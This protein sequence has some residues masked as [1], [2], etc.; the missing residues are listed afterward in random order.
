MFRRYFNRTVAQQD[1][2]LVQGNPFLK[3]G[4]RERVPELM[5]MS[6]RQTRAPKNLLQNLVPM[7][8]RPLTSPPPRPEKIIAAVF[9]FREFVQHNLRQRYRNMLAGFL[10]VQKY[11]SVLDRIFAQPDG[12]P[13]SQTGMT[14]RQNK[15][16]RPRVSAPDPVL[17]RH[18]LGCIQD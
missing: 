2:N 6:L 13:D 14:H 18:V 7:L 4:D 8:R 11:F 5:R 17:E 12:I 3:Q 1:R 9:D 15:G 10:G 16:L